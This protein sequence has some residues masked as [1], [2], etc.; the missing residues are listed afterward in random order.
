MSHCLHQLVEENLSRRYLP[1]QQQMMELV[2]KRGEIACLRIQQV[3]GVVGVIRE[4]DC[5]RIVVLPKG[6]FLPL[7]EHEEVRTEPF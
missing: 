4:R 3:V 7:A 2:E 6:K 5:H 1:I